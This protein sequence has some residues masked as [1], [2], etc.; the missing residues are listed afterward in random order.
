MLNFAI[1]LR[2]LHCNRNI[3]SLFLNANNFVMGLLQML[4]VV[5]FYSIWPIGFR[6]EDFYVYES[7]K[8]AMFL[9]QNDQDL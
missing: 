3:C 2:Q 6:Q 1:K 5:K 8:A 9:R 7:S 4:S